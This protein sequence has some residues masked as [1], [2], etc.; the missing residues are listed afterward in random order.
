MS[1]RPGLEVEHVE[2]LAPLELVKLIVARPP[3]LTHS[4]SVSVDG[5]NLLQVWSRYARM[6]GSDSPASSLCIM[7]RVTST[8]ILQP[9]AW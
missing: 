7:S 1:G 4:I 8:Q 2:Y 5:P 9:A 3:T 6:T